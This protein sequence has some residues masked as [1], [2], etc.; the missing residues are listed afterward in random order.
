MQKIL[1]FREQDVLNIEIN[2][3]SCHSTNESN[4]K[5]ADEFYAEVTRAFLKFCERKLYKNAAENFL[6][7][8]QSDEKTFEIFTA[9]MDF[10]I[11]YSYSDELPDR[12]L[13]TKIHLDVDINGEKRHKIYSLMN[14]IVKKKKRKSKEKSFETDYLR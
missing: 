5:K 11:E 6:L 10:N 2:Y 12:P 9:K 1:T 13:N 8:E 14:I 7:L 4:D 3:P